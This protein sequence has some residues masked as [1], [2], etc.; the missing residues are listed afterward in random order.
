MENGYPEDLT[1]LKF[2]KL[3]VVYKC[4]SP[5]KNSYHCKCECGNECDFRRSLLIRRK[6]CGECSYDHTVNG[7]SSTAIY[8]RYLSMFDR[9]YNKNNP[10]YD[11]YGGRGIKVCDRWK[12]CYGNF[13]EDMY[14]SFRKHA[15]I[16]G[17][18]DTTLDRLDCDGDYCKENCRWL[19]NA[20]QQRNKSSNV[21]ITIDGVTK[22]LA[23]WIDTSEIGDST[24]RNR[25][26][27]GMDPKLA[28]TKPLREKY[29][30]YY[31]GIPVVK[32]CADNN[33]NYHLVINRLYMG[34]DLESA[35]EAPKGVR[36]KDWINKDDNIP[37][38][39]RKPLYYKGLSLKQYCV[40]NNISYPMV[41]CRIHAGWNIDDALIA[42]K[43]TLLKTWLKM[44]ENN[45]N[46]LDNSE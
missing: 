41:L 42:P 8:A 44:K 2:G 1:G 17:E 9:C 30:L 27:V 7:D 35:V 43:G 5:K 21:L 28:L 39:I 25:I 15:E 10:Y 11:R 14:D 16:Y 19:T 22:V 20:E 26:H 6:S 38:K 29:S 3:E 32:Y 37:L 24:V 18:H 46:S 33:I 23:D 31:N 36:Y 34:W 13:K 45:K 40:K 12:E 4:E